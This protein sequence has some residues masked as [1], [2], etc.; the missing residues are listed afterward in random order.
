MNG[1][2]NGPAKAR[3][4]CSWSAEERADWVR[5]LEQSGQ[6]LSE[7]CRA[8]GLHESTVSLWRKQLREPASEAA[9]PE[10]FIEVDLPSAPSALVSARS[11]VTVRLT[12]R[13]SFDVPSAPIRPGSPISSDNCARR[14]RRRAVQG[15]AR[16][17]SVPETRRD[18]L[19][20]RLRGTLAAR[21]EA[22]LPGAD[23]RSS[24]RLLQSCS[25]SRALFVLGWIWALGGHQ[26]RRA[27]YDRLAEGQRADQ[28]TEQQTIAAVAG[29]LRA[30]QSQRLVPPRA[31]TLKNIFSKCWF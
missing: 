5:L 11:T 23:R 4:R 14:H 15:A 30:A 17:A 31:A 21:G 10:D 1:K 7:F 12:G 27:R 24:L 25:Q 6:G 22:L 18:G 13:V 16:H 8:N 28:R 20:A 9:N 26:A 3:T 29:G 19:E 2:E